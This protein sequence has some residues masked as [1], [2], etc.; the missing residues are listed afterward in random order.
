MWL[1]LVHR[2]E[3]APL[4]IIRVGVH[5]GCSDHIFKEGMLVFWEP[6]E[7]SYGGPGLSESSVSFAPKRE[8]TWPMRRHTGDGKYSVS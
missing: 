8:V 6:V 7:E 3:E 2:A 1:R 5:S 4:G